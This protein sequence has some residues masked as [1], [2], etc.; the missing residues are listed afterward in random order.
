MSYKYSE[1]VEEPFVNSIGQ[2]INPG[3]KV[4]AITTGYGHR[5]N[6]ITGVFEGVRRQN[7]STKGIVGSRIGGV[8]VKRTRSVY[9]EDG[10]HAEMKYDY[11]T[12]K[13]IPSGRR[14][15]LVTEVT[16]RKSSLQRNR[17]FKV[18]TNLSEVRSI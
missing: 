15:N 17:V 18:D 2:T 12:R 16:Y 3:D 1:L 9:S 10:E 4:V 7:S 14:Y 5:V 8:P 11:T 13:Y 6:I